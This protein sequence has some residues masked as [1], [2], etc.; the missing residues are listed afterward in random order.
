VHS[1]WRRVHA[2]EETDDSALPLLIENEL[3]GPMRLDVVLTDWLL[4]SVEETAA[5]FWEIVVL[6]REIRRVA[7]QCLAMPDNSIAFAKDK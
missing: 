7:P 5:L 1:R 3:G 6:V 2:H 4:D